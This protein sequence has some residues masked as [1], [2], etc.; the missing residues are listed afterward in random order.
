M[1]E[2]RLLNLPPEIRIMIW[3]A[4][5]SLDDVYGRY[6]VEDHTTVEYTYAQLPA[7]CKLGRICRQIRNEVFEE[8][9]NRTLFVRYTNMEWYLRLSLSHLRSRN[10]MVLPVLVMIFSSP[11]LLQNVRHLSL[12]WPRF[13]LRYDPF[14]PHAMRRLANAP[15][16]E[17]VEIVFTESGLVDRYLDEFEW[18]RVTTR[19]EP[20]LRDYFG[21]MDD[22]DGGDNGDDS[23]DGGNGGDGDGGDHNALQ[24][25]QLFKAQVLLPLDKITFRLAFERARDVE[26]WE[27]TEWFR[28]IKQAVEEAHRSKEKEV[29]NDNCPVP[30]SARL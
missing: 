24:A 20:V 21:A 22:G 5:W 1:T 7:I 3:K 30:R 10:Q 27:K 19:P 29:S 23:G 14:L 8:F 13:D 12:H 25:V 16:L 2:S 11:F 26:A 17:T 18:P 15:K 9:F 28:N 4:A 6:N